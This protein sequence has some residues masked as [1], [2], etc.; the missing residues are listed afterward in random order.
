MDQES[1]FLHEEN[2]YIPNYL[3]HPKCQAL[4]ADLE[5]KTYSLPGQLWLNWVTY[6]NSHH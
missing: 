2:Q 1:D 3:T 5:T 6:K 4:G